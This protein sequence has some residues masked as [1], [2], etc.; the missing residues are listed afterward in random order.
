MLAAIERSG[1][2]ATPTTADNQTRE[3]IIRAARGLFLER[4]SD[5]AAMSEL[6]KR[7][8]VTT[9][10]L[11]WHFA[12]KTQLCEAVLDRDYRDFLKEL[13][14]RTVG[15]TPE[16]Q[17]RAF[18]ATYVELQIRDREGWFNAGYMQLHDKVSDSA[19]AEI[20]VMTTSVIDT[21]KRILREGHESGDFSIPDLTLA[22]YALMTACEYVY[23]WYKPGGRLSPQ[24]VGAVYA[25]LALNVV[26]PA[27]P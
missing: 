12:S 20:N 19:R 13:T 17:L 21:L 9:P 11:Y 4:G 10:A 1:M 25:D 26:K 27:S 8:G 24:Q 6:A 16:Q 7:S 3:R 5:G 22:T 2:S 23:V 15:G 14:E 18:V